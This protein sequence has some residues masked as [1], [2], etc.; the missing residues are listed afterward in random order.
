L[1]FQSKHLCKQ[2]FSIS[3][4]KERRHDATTRQDRTGPDT[5]RQNDATT[6]RQDKTRQDKTRQDKTRQDNTKH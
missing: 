1:P 5:T 6:T 3:S 4:D 2:F